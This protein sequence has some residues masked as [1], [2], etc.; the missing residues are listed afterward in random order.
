MTEP[1]IRTLD[2]TE[3]DVEKPPRY[4]DERYYADG[5]VF[6]RY[7][8][9][10]DARE[11]GIVEGCVL[12]VG[13]G[14]QLAAYRKADELNALI[15][16]WRIEQR[17]GKEAVRLA[18]ESVPTK[19]KDSTIESLG[20][21]FLEYSWRLRFMTPLARQDYEWGIRTF[22]NEEYKGYPL[23]LYDIEEL[24][25]TDAEEIYEQ[26]AET[27]GTINANT[28]IS[29]MRRVYNQ[30]IEWGL[31]DLNPFAR[32]KLELKPRR[33]VVE[34]TDEQRARLLEEADSNPRWDRLRRYLLLAHFTGISNREAVDLTWNDINLE[35]RR[36]TVTRRGKKL[37]L[38]I[39]DELLEHMKEWD[40]DV[41]HVLHQRSGSPMTSPHLSKDLQRLRE[42][43]GLP[44]ELKV[45]DAFKSK[46]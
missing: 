37:R 2:L 29:A 36:I 22:I 27:R 32:F 16:E 28:T 24:G 38:E 44:S 1:R 8:P 33:D 17:Y 39:P 42:A 3:E 26:L 15:D 35:A 46:E 4:V 45:T 21:A 34:W 7:V 12:G 43:A 40:K 19:L 14:E 10:K 31:T 6:W 13:E 5:T 25:R 9:P 41:P 18:K 30:A 11:E 20:E 23:G